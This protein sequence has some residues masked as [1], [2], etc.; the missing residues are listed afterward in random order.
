MRWFSAG[1]HR[2][3][4]RVCLDR[5]DIASRTG[6]ALFLLIPFLGDMSQSWGGRVSSGCESGNTGSSMLWQDIHLGCLCS[7]SRPGR[8]HTG[9]S[10]P[11]QRTRQVNR[12]LIE[13]RLCCLEDHATA[14]RVIRLDRCPK[15]AG[16]WTPPETTKERSASSGDSSN[17]ME[18]PL[19]SC[20]IPVLTQPRSTDGSGYLQTPRKEKNG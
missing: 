3:G 9:R 1:G 16:S 8:G 15:K 13:S 11:G 5:T 6:Y 20:L 10:R 12:R 18:A 7:G 2:R 19:L 14:Q 4:F 17:P